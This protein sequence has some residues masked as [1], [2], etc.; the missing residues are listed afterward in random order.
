MSNSKT[1]KNR[2]W[3]YSDD[4]RKPRKTFI[5][6]CFAVKQEKHMDY[7]FLRLASNLLRLIAYL[8]KQ[9]DLLNQLGLGKV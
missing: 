3:Y 7:I 9:R 2:T 4:I 1:I 5:F 6:S 8:K